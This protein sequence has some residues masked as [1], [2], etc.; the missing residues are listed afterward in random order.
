M[1]QQPDVIPDW[2]LSEVG[3]L[4]LENQA[5]RRALAEAQAEGVGVR[6]RIVAALKAE[7]QEYNKASPSGTEA[8]VCLRAAEIAAE[9]P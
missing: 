2:V 7:A 3:R 1:S 9:V 5:L 8:G 4:H 6:G